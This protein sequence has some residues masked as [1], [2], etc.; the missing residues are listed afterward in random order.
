MK[1][2]TMLVQNFG[3]QTRWIVRVLQMASGAN[4]Y[5]YLCVWDFDTLNTHMHDRMQTKLFSTYLFTF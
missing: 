3:G 4:F 2:K 1:L 5:S